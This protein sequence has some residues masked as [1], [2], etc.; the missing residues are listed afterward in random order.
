MVP[1]IFMDGNDV[2]IVLYDCVQDVLLLST[3][4]KYRARKMLDPVGLL[5]VWLAINHR[6]I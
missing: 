1:V 6:Y 5:V 3:K 2:Q 4:V